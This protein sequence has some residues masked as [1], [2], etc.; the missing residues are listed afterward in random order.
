M[1]AGK[2]VPQVS[3]VDLEVKG[4]GLELVVAQELRD[5]ADIDALLFD[6]PS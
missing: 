1:S 3:N 2:D 4:C 6:A 5:L